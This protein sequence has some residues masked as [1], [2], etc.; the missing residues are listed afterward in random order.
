[1]RETQDEMLMKNIFGCYIR[2]CVYVCVRYDLMV[3]KKKHIF[4]ITKQAN[5]L[6]IIYT[7]GVRANEC[8]C[9]TA[10]C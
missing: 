7:R 1:M 2:I 6:C 9:C 10:A 3:Q 5:I 4:K 8:N